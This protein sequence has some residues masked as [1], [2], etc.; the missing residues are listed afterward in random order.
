MRSL[1]DHNVGGLIIFPCWE[2]RET[3][4]AFAG[5]SRPLVVVNRT[6]E[7]QPGMSLV[8]NRIRRGARLAVDHLAGRGHRSIGMLAGRAAPLQIMERMQGFREG[9]QA[10]GLPFVA[11]W[12]VADDCNADVERGYRAARRLMSHHPEVT[13]L[14]AY[15]DL[16]AAGALQAC[17]DLGRRVPDDMAIVGFDDIQFAAMMQPALTT[18]YIDKYDLGRQAV[19]RLLEMLNEPGSDLEPIHLDVEL[20]VRQST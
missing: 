18:V 13:A 1:V 4:R 10:N 17:R 15:N 6:F 11:D 19:T 8:L 16:I 20:V 7:P 12:V 3:L 9:L 2:N 5:L 14:F